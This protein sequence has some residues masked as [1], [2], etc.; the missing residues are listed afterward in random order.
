[1]PI[2][3]GILHQLTAALLFSLAVTFT[4]RVRRP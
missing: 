2:W 1:V 4:W 3:L